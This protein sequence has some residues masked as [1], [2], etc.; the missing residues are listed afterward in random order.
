M[1]QPIQSDRIARF[2]TL[3]C[4]E[5]EERT[6]EEMFQRMTARI[7]GVAGPD[8]APESL[9]RICAAWDV[10]YGRMLAWL[11]ADAKRYS[12][13]ERALEV[14]AHELISQTV[15]IADGEGFPQDKRI[16]IETRFKLARHHAPVKYGERILVQGESNVIFID[17]GLVGMAAQLLE[18]VSQGRGREIDITPSGAP[19]PQDSEGEI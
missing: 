3:T 5:A 15:G 7:E 14:A 2:L 13:Y 9:A 11:M 17:A 19:L 1:S 10:P 8:G 12:I 18:K 6:L 4:E 16:R